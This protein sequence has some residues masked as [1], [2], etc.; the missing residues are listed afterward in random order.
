MIRYVDDL[1]A[2]ADPDAPALLWRGSPIRY[3]VLNRMVEA[4]AQS[5]QA[6]GL[7]PG[8]RVAVYLAKTPETVAAL[9]AASRAGMVFVPVNPV[10]RPAQVRHILEDSAAEIL[11]TSAARLAALR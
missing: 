4:A 7:A 10:L 2:A 6:L 1:P 11:V 8:A 3:A 9:F 5:W